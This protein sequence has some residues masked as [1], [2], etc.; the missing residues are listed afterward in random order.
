MLLFYGLIIYTL[1]VYGIAWLITQSHL[2]EG[3]RSSIESLSEK[4]EGKFG[5]GLLQKVG[6]LA[7]CIVC[8]SVWV[9][10][11]LALGSNYSLLLSEAFPPVNLLDLVIWAGWSA[12]TSW[13]LANLLDDAG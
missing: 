3:F 2:F 10:V 9:G 6:Y 4:R 11:L 13:L 7:N 5:G 1:S 8:T 12:S